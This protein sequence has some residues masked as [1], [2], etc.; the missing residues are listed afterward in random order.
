MFWSDKVRS[1]EG[2]G[3]GRAMERTTSEGSSGYDTNDKISRLIVMK[4]EV[5]ERAVKATK[6]NN[7]QHVHFPRALIH[8]SKGGVLR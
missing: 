6:R 1:F 2:G 7:V 8:K 5:T 3:G 4:H